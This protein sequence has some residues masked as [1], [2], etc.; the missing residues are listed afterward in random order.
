MGISLGEFIRSVRIEK[1]ISVRAFA[2]I[3]GIS[4]NYLNNLEKGYDP[5]TKKEIVPSIETLKVIAGG[6]G[7]QLE[8]L[9][10][11]TGHIENLDKT[12]EEAMRDKVK[13]EILALAEKL[14]L[15]EI[16]AVSDIVERGYS[17][18]DLRDALANI[19]KKKNV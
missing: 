5:R 19:I 15:D 16:R 13:N 9:L 4:H 12:I 8:D 17:L 2:K 1:G 7:L 6:L 10:R 14:S 11:F 3:I 18:V